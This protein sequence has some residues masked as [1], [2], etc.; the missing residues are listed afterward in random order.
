MRAGVHQ[1][2]GG[3]G[4]ACRES[5]T[6]FLADTV[7]SLGGVPFFGDAMG[8][9]A[10]YRCAIAQLGSAGMATYVSCLMAARGLHVCQE[11][12]CLIL[13]GNHSPYVRMH[14][15]ERSYAPKGRSTHNV[16]TVQRLAKGARGAAGRGAPH[17]GAPRL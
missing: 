3:I 5:G 8:V 10:M 12:Q 16:C 7:C 15:T 6:L 14:C 11:A 2:F 4:D 13:R 17:A 1:P 9:D